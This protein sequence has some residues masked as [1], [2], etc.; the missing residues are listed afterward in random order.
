MTSK[1]GKQTIAIRV[2]PNISR[3]KDN[4]A[5]KFGHLIEYNMRAIFIEKLY[6]KY[7]TSLR[8]SSDLRICLDKESKAAITLIYIFNCFFI[9][10]YIKGLFIWR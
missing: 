9:N 1:A 7:E 3:S 4:Q 8:H 2:L 10:L 5:M 6:T